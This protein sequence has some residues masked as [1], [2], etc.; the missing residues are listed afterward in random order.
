M[1]QLNSGS[2][3]NRV[4]SIQEKVHGPSVQNYEI[5]YLFVKRTILQKGKKQFLQS[6]INCALSSTGGDYAKPAK[7][8]LTKLGA[9]GVWI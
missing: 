3:Y 8:F 5:P 6:I 7:N 9:D 1:K 4:E 2:Q